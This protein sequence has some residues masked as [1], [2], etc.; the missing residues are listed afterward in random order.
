[1]KISLICLIGSVTL[2]GCRDM[3]NESLLQSNA[4]SNGS[5]D[6][7]PRVAS[8]EQLRSL[9]IEKDFPEA[10][11][12]GFAFRSENGLYFVKT[13]SRVNAQGD[14]LPGSWMDDSFFFGDLQNGMTRLQ[15]EQFGPIAG[16]KRVSDFYD[17]SSNLAGVRAECC[18]IFSGTGKVQLEFHDWKDDGSKGKVLLTMTS[19]IKS[20]VAEL[21]AKLNEGQISLNEGP[22]FRDVKFILFD[23]QKGE[24][25][26]AAQRSP[27]ELKV[28]DWSVWIGPPGNF[29]RLGAAK[30]VKKDVGDSYRQVEVVVPDLG[31]ILWYQSYDGKSQVKTATLTRQGGSTQST[32]LEEIKWDVVKSETLRP[33]LEKIKIAPLSDFMPRSFSVTDFIKKSARQ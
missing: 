24:Y 11:N 7:K 8:P 12:I 4:T 31:T 22:V 17:Y 33:H 23:K 14:Y 26:F 2:I 32:P 30:V 29:R 19:L 9:Q 28:D 15:H 18:S 13:A 5:E 6:L 1:M 16:N 25:I 21:Q 27:H 20:E 3:G 10:R